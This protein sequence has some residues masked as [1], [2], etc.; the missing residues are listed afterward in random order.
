MAEEEEAKEGKKGKEK[1]EKGKSNLVPAIVVAIGLIFAGKMLG[2]GKSATPA[3]ALPVAT[4]TAESSDTLDCK[5]EDIK[6]PPKEGP[7]DKLDAIS[8]NLANGHYAKVGI[9]LQLSSAVNLETFKAEG[10][11]VKALDKVI[12][13]IGGRDMAEFGSPQAIEAVKEK[14]TE[15]VR[16]AFKCEVLEV[17]F[18][19]FVMQ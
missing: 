12:A 6:K 18:T 15:E 13:V 3:T 17:L 8:I 1:K 7:V 9:A 11:E 16:P 10:A 2:G 19:E 14:I 5:V 4:A